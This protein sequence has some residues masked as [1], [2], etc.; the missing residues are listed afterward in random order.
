MKKIC[1]INAKAAS[2]T[3]KK[4]QLRVTALQMHL[5][6]TEYYFE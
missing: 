2:N 3:R 1:V 4:K 6:T 5:K